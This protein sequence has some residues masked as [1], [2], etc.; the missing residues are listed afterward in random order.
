[1]HSICAKKLNN[2]IALKSKISDSIIYDS[3]IVVYTNESV[4][5]SGDLEG[6][7][8]C[9]SIA[10]SIEQKRNCIPTM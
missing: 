7:W 5:K 9:V 3:I 1:M 6:D 10:K 4:Q 2:R 8:E